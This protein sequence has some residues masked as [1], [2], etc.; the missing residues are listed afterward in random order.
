MLRCFM[1]K[2]EHNCLSISKSG[3]SCI[4]VYRFCLLP[5]LSLNKTIRKHALS[6][7][8]VCTYLSTNKALMFEKM[9]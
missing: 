8:V 5:L 1:F 6:F 7:I 2:L 9:E 3:Q 4:L